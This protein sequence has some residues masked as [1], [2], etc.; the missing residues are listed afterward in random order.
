MGA[1]SQICA[2][3]RPTERCVVFM[4]FGAGGR[5][6]DHQKAEIIGVESHAGEVKVHR[7]ES[8]HAKRRQFSAS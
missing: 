2:R 5:M 6:I 3:S 1:P 8:L 7:I 4:A